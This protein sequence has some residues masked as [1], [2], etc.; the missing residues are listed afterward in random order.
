MYFRVRLIALLVGLLTLVGMLK[1][2]AGE[3]TV[4]SISVP[5]YFAMR[6]GKSIYVRV[7]LSNKDTTPSEGTLIAT[8]DGFPGLT[9]QQDFTIAADEDLSV[10]IPIYLPQSVTPGSRIDA[11][12]ALQ[13]KTEGEV[14]NV[15]KDG[16]RVFDT[17]PIYID[18]DQNVS[19]FLL[20]PSPTP[21]MNWEWRV[22]EV[23]RTY[24]LGVSLRVQAGLTRRAVNLSAP[25]VSVDTNAW[26]GY[27]SV[28]IGSNDF[29]K[30]L[31]IVG[32]MRNWIA[33]GGRLW[34][35][36]DRVDPKLV[37]PLL[38]ASG[39]IHVMGTTELD[40]IHIKTTDMV[41]AGDE[42]MNYE[43]Q[44]PAR[45]I[46]IMAEGLDVTHT[47]D[48]W[49]AVAWAKIGQGELLLTTLDATA[50]VK[51]SPMTNRPADPPEARTG[52]NRERFSRGF[53]IVAEMVTTRYSARPWVG[54]LP[55]RFFGPRETT[56]RT[57][58][59]SA[60]AADR[61]GLPVFS[62]SVVLGLLT[63]FLG[64]LIAGSW[65]LQNKGKL[66][67]LGW[68]GPVVAILF[69]APV[70]LMASQYR[71]DVQPQV[72][73]VQSVDA[74]AGMDQMVVTE[75]A[76]IY[77]PTAEPFGIASKSGG[78]FIPSESLINQ[79]FYRVE[80]PLELWSW[81]A[82][83][84]PAGI[85]SFE[86]RF[87]Y[88]LKSV[89]MVGKFTS[90]GLEIEFPDS[91][92][93]PTPFE[94]VIV[95]WP[96]T[97]AAIA[98]PIGDKKWLVKSE[99][100]VEGGNWVSGTILSD[101]QLD[102]QKVYD[103]LLGHSEVTQDIATTPSVLGWSTPLESPMKPIREIDYKGQ[104]MWR[105]NL[106][107]TKPDA[108][109][110]VVVPSWAVRVRAIQN[111]TGFS[112]AYRDSIGKWGGKFTQATN[113]DLRYELPESCRPWTAKSATLKLRALA[114]ERTIRIS[115]I[116]EGGREILSVESPTGV[117]QADLKEKELEQLSKGA[118]ELRVDVG[119]LIKKE[120]LKAGE[121]PKAVY[122]QIDFLK[123][124][125]EGTAA[126]SS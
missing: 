113:V 8:L 49:P 50:W 5:S 16:A 12:V 120:E 31:A 46:K 42:D 63:G 71:K 17:A 95:S 19:L 88:P 75:S 103:S 85:W 48:G 73:A 22:D 51:E 119:D 123:L 82:P 125:V 45:F 101:V 23:H 76:S 40:R 37:G 102:R 53:S 32:A 64:I 6:P 104:S 35:M 86:N 62:R 61:I 111:I 97:Q 13:L 105:L 121:P 115:S 126:N 96:P 89:S 60:M 81:S 79:P 116:G 24:E 118:I 114:P 44:P 34:I 100:L 69:S 99:N 80:R 41:T 21:P 107:M 26:D 52:R 3:A 33:R 10:L 39:L 30:D 15:Q 54:T 58:A 68:I 110:K 67:H 66:E 84:W 47:I 1:A 83:R 65:F 78:R 2:G 109:A 122:W 106:R 36:L 14:V 59:M 108:G 27:D 98:K 117:V 28:V 74:T 25:P 92:S 87:E 29:L 72:S 56:Y 70:V 9:F 112:V 124:E 55:R 38:G 77:Q 20:E 94:D 90:E 4:T 43:M 91:K 57:Q 18:P 93:A 7:E 11:K